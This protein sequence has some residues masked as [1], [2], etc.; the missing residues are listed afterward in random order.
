MFTSLL[1]SQVGAQ[2]NSFSGLDHSYPVNA[3]WV[4]LHVVHGRDISYA[5]ASTG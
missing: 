4:G 2:V 1:S 5:N 3:N